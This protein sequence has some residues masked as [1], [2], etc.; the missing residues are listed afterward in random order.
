V[1]TIRDYKIQWLR[2]DIVAGIVLS[3]MLVPV[4]VAYAVA[5]GLPAINGLYATII[6]LIAYAIF[7]PSRV[8]VLGPDS[9]LTPIILGVVLPLAAGDPQRAVALGSAMAIVSG[10]ACI[11]AGI[12]RLGFITELLS[13]PIRYG[14][15]NGIALAVLI[16]QL[17]KVF[18]FSI[19][20]TGPLRDL[21]AI[22]SGVIAG[23]ANLVGTMLGI[24]TLA[25]IM[26]LK[27]HKRMGAILVAMI[28]AIFI[29]DWFDLSQNFGV[30]VLGA[31]P[32]GLPEFAIPWLRPDDIVPVIEAGLAVAIVS[33][34]DTSV[35]SRTFAARSGRYVDPNQE[36][37][38]LGAA[39]LATGFFLGFPISSSASRTPIAEAAGAK[40][41]V[42]GLIGALV[43]ALVIVAAPQLFKD[44]PNSAL[45]AVV[46]SAA[47]G[48]FEFDD[49]ARIYRIQRWEFW[50]S[51][52]CTVAVA[53]FGAIPGIGIAVVVAI[54]QFLWAGWR[55]HWAVLG[56]AEGVDGYHDVTRYPD[57]QTVPGLVLFRWDA[58]LFFANAE[59]FNERVLG[60]IAASPTSVRRLVIAAEPITNIDVTSADMLTELESTLQGDD[61]ELC[62][63]ELKDPVKDKLKRFGLFAR[64][65]ENRFFPTKEF[66]VRNYLDAMDPVRSSSVGAV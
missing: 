16:S 50:L 32:Q 66:A 7:G 54:V 39:N 24:G 49:L 58:P 42:T 38:G 23:K 48:L 4:G 5:S 55:P 29:A 57:A 1:A 62:F 47:I 37:V 64:F 65:G 8:L 12:G 18:G 59:L 30:K 40:T 13:K 45:A 14:F 43:V 26:I 10:L 60:A 3:T 53:T 25:V 15:M 61:I 19:E 28:G 52:L 36:M 9:S 33:F 6:P 51:I 63:A 35:L 31:V 20:S 44:L 2:S 22:A 41:Q 17:P 21:W 11:V 46:I 34:T 27:A 56:K